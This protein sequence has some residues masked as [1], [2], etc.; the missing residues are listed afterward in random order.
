MCTV[1]SSEKQDAL[2]DDGNIF[3]KNYFADVQAIFSRVQHHMH[4]RTKNGFVPL[5]SCQRKIGKSK[6][7]GVTCKADFPKTNLCLPST[8]HVCRGLAKKL[9][10]RVSGRRN[11]LGSFVGKRYLLEMCLEKNPSYIVDLYSNM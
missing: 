3:K 1:S 4:K 5:K 10:L 11:A 2:R 7:A 6:K 9:K 8:V